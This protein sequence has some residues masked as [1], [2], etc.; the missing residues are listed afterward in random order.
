M[1]IKHIAH[2]TISHNISA[3]EDGLQTV[4]LTVCFSGNVYAMFSKAYSHLQKE[5]KS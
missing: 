3:I 2:Y 1:I 4:C 5:T